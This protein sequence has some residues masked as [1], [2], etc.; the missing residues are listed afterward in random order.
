[1]N[2]EMKQKEKFIFYENKDKVV[3]GLWISNEDELVK[4]Y[5]KIKEFVKQEN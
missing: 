3:K 5:D 4:L 1:M 2:I